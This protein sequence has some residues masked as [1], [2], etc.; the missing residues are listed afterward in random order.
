MAHGT[1]PSM[2]RTAR[3]ISCL[4]PLVLLQAV[5]CTWLW[6]A[7]VS[8]CQ[9]VD[10]NGGGAGAS[11]LVRCTRQGS[12]GT[13]RRAVV[14]RLH[15]NLLRRA[16]NG[17]IATRVRGGGARDNPAIHLFRRLRARVLAGRAY[18]IAC[19]RPQ[20]NW[21]RTPGTPAD[22]PNDV[23]ASLEAGRPR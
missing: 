14:A 10:L 20:S 15:R 16:S 3:A 22:Q 2:T 11:C 1:G 21:P 4:Y 7:V 17:S 18:P 23:Q 13:A 8:K 19:P 12:Q 6:P 9:R 5:C